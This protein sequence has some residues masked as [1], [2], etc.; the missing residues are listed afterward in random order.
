VC[1]GE[2]GPLLIYY[3]DDSTSTFM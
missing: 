3:A 2:D 1:S